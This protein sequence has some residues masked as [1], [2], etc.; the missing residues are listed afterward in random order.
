MGWRGLRD[1]VAAAAG[2]GV[3]FAE[4]ARR[5]ASE[6][7]YVLNKEVKDD[8]QLLNFELSRSASG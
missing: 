3:H 6:V 1:V 2:H 5:A 7:E 8:A 4:P